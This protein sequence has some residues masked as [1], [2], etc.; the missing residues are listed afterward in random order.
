[1]GQ[2]TSSVGASLLKTI[3]KVAFEEFDGDVLSAQ[4]YVLG[5]LGQPPPGTFIPSFHIKVKKEKEPRL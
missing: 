1:M 5:Q 3:T 4:A 2:K